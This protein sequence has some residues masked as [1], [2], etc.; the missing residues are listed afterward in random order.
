MR[1][2]KESPFSYQLPR[3]LGTYNAP[4][5]FIALILQ[6]LPIPWVIL[7]CPSALLP[8]YHPVSPFPTRFLLS[9]D[10][11]VHS[12]FPRS[13]QSLLE[14]QHSSNAFSPSSHVAACALLRGSRPDS[15][16]VGG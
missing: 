6:I 9:S 2:G 10:P 5:S 12:R 1:A 7:H 14:H 11:L 8:I 13:S 4:S 16:A 3:E 15:R